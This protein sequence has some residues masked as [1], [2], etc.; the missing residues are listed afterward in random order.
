[1]FDNHFP[2]SSYVS[3]SISENLK[4]NKVTDWY[5]SAELIGL[6]DY[7]GLTV[8]NP[9]IDEN[10]KPVQKICSF[11]GVGSEFTEEP[12]SAKL[13]IT[14]FYKKQGFDQFIAKSPVEKIIEINVGVHYAFELPAYAPE[15]YFPSYFI[16]ESPT[17]LYNKKDPNVKITYTTESFE[18]YDEYGNLTTIQNFWALYNNTLTQ[19]N[20]MGYNMNNLL[21]N[22]NIFKYLDV[23]SDYYL[24]VKQNK[25]YINSIMDSEE[26]P[27]DLLNVVG[28]YVWNG[29]SWY[30][31]ETGFYITRHDVR[32]WRWTWYN[33]KRS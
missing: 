18:V 10:G 21:T 8:I 31:S 14:Y 4:N 27:A 1:M 7:Y 30:C 15:H 17:V 9:V 13:K 22:K 32:F 25:Y 11:S 26:V 29:F 3:R 12:I 28:T 33:I 16:P 24:T 23:I 6:T 5:L 2:I 20:L 19:D